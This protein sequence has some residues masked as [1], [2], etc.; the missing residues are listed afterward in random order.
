MEK[1]WIPHDLQADTRSAIEGLLGLD[2]GDRIADNAGDIGSDEFD[3][4]VDEAMN[5]IR[6]QRK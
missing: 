3:A 6:P 1:V 5:Q 2:L 4:A